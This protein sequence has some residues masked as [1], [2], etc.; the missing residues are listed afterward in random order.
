MVNDALEGKIDLIRTKSLSRFA[1]NTADVLTTSR[2]P[3][4]AG[5][6]FCFQRENVST[7]PLPDPMKKDS[8]RQWISAVLS[9]N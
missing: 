6:A 4:S 2:K 8:E 7:M 1:R 9:P 5:E 3:K